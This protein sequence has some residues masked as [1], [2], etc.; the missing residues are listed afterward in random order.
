MAEK[1]ILI[2]AGE[3][4]G[5]INAGNLAKAL[6]E[7]RPGLNI[8][9]IGGD[10]MRKAGVRIYYDI[11]NFSVI[12]LFDV[13]KKLPKFINLKNFILKKI[14]EEKP[15]AI[16]LVDFSGFNLR[17]A[18]SINK[19]IPVIY[20]VSPQVWASREGR[21]RTIKK[22]IDKM[23]VIFA[24]EKEFYKRHGI[25]ADFVGHP[26]LDKPKP[27]LAKE[28]FINKYGLLPDRTNILLLPGSR[29]SE[30]SNILPVMAETAA[31]IKQ[32]LPESQFIIGKSANVEQGI[33]EKTLKRFSGIDFKIIEGKTFDCLNIADFSLVASG[34]A[35][36][37]TAVMQKPFV[38]IY[39]MGMLNYLLYRPQVKVPYIGMVNIVAGK[40][41]VP[42]FI[43]NNA[44]AKVIADYVVYTL[45]KTD[46]LNQIRADLS[47]VKS[48]LGEPGASK[49]AAKII[50]T[51]LFENR[52]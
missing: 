24:F 43:Q 41:L 13:L 26:L 50:G 3:A 47:Q 39:K 20:Y 2:I 23:I 9:G 51:V 1:H 35:T 52:P 19:K 36:L 38:V 29:K 4:S 5:D 11:K 27:A 17:L 10:C 30:V 46:L 15:C 32:A 33:F 45:G 31:L 8:S 12:G 16:I 25:D 28:E 7:S 37:E 18:K 21:I 14:K 42:E 40:K 22:Y 34:T 49:R 6:F 48:L 44:R